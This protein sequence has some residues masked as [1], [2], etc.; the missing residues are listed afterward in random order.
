MGLSER[1]NG[2]LILVRLLVELAEQLPRLM[3]LR[4]LLDFS[5]EAE[6]S[7]LHFALCDELSC[8]C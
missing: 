8:P 1:D 7:L 5:F 6:H 2:L 3:V 4:I